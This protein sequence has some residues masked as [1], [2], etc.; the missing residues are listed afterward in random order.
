MKTC[1][2]VIGHKKASPG[3]ENTSSGVTEFA[4]NEQLAME[5][6]QKVSGVQIQRV[7]R[8]TYKTLPGDINELE[9]D[10]SISLHCN[11]FNQT[12]SGTEVLFYHRSDKGRQMAEI[13]NEKL[14]R[15]LGLKNRGVQPKTAEDRGGYLLKNAAA[16][17]VIA[18]PFFIDNDM[19]LEAATSKR[20]L[21]VSAYAEGIE[22]IA[23]MI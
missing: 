12:A 21:L 5:I 4:F 15:A 9:P 13:L 16:P 18:E 6:E 20:Q 3:A 10:F 17:C 14:V 11:A 19:D 8:R 22:A 1:A 23:D 7:Y 2:L